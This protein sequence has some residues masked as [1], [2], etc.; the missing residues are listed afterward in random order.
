MPVNLRQQLIDRVKGLAAQ[1]AELAAR[2]NR[3]L[4]NLDTQITAANAL[5]RQWDT[6]T[7]DQALA[8]VEQAGLRVEVK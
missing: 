2:T 1:R 8:L 6:L 4:A 3:E 5:A 7:P